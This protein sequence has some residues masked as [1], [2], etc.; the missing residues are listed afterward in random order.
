MYFNSFPLP[1]NATLA[2]RHPHLIISMTRSTLG[3]SFSLV[4]PNRFKFTQW[5]LCLMPPP[6]PL[7][8]TRPRK[9][10]RRKNLPTSGAESFTRAQH[11]RSRDLCRPSADCSTVSP[12]TFRAIRFL[13][14][15]SG[16]WGRAV[17]NAWNSTCTAPPCWTRPNS[18]F[19]V[20]PG[21]TTR[22]VTTTLRTT[23]P[24]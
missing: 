4:G 19:S 6:N 21:R 13:V 2:E 1:T 17:P 11:Y 9:Q 5:Y 10:T 3:G 20:L 14:E 22:A 24:F 16:T 23:P 7:T 15:S 8:A 12:C 18:P